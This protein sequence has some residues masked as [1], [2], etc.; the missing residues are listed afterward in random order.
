MTSLKW[1]FVGVIF[2]LSALGCETWCIEWA[3]E[4]EECHGNKNDDYRY[5]STQE[6]SEIDG[7]ASLCRF[8]SLQCVPFPELDGMSICVNECETDEDCKYSPGDNCEGGYC[9]YW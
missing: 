1:I 8:D 2:S 7:F 4:H 9:V 6:C 5:T 3:D